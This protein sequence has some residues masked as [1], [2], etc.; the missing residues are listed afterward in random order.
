MCAYTIHRVKCKS[1]PSGFGVREV[2][3]ADAA[4]EGWTSREVV[5]DILKEHKAY[6]LGNVSASYLM[7]YIDH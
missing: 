4:R 2:P 6:D 5:V 7:M 3:L 1:P